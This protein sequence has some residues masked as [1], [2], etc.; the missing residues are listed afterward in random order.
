ME[1]RTCIARALAELLWVTLAEMLGTHLAFRLPMRKKGSFIVC[2]F[3]LVNYAFIRLGMRGEIN[4]SGR[5]RKRKERRTKKRRRE[6]QRRRGRHGSCRTAGDG[7][8]CLL[9][10][11]VGG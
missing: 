3:E 10:Q 5:R 4:E 7:G 11:F 6:K 1:V 2:I 8:T 9:S